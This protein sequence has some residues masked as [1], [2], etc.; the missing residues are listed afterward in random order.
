MRQFGEDHPDRTAATALEIESLEPL[1]GAHLKTLV[2]DL[3]RD[4]LNRRWQCGGHRVRLAVDKQAGRVASQFEG[5]GGQV[6]QYQLG[7]KEPVARGAVVGS[8]QEGQFDHRH[9]LLL[10]G[11]GRDHRLARLVQLLQLDFKCLNSLD[12]R[13]DQRSVLE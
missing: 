8:T 11:V 5:S 9:D 2:A 4:I 13:P 3:K 12:Q 7:R 6:D 10:G 1:Q